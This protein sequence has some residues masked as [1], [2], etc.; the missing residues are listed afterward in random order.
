MTLANFAIVLFA[1]FD[2]FKIVSLFVF[3]F[4]FGNFS[5]TGPTI[6]VY[7]VEIAPSGCIPYCY[8]TF[9]FYSV[10]ILL[11]FPIIKGNYLVMLL[12]HTGF[13][14]FTGFGTITLFSGIYFYKYGLETKDRTNSEIS[15]LFLS[16]RKSV[17]ESLTT[18]M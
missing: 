11:L 9:W 8:W 6:P 14:C 5:S 7:L 2:Q 10:I 15:N 17:V 13:Y 1:S 16:K 18:T 4:V 3:L 12:E